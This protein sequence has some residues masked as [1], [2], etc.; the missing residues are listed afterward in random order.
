MPVVGTDGEGRGEQHRR[1]DA[2]GGTSETFGHCGCL[3]VQ[4]D[5]KLVFNVD[6][7]VL[8]SCCACVLC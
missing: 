5:D 8:L 7:H 6:P 3:L 4:R 1:G 2:L